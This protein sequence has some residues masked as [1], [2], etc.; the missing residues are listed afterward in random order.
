MVYGLPVPDEPKTLIEYIFPEIR[1]LR[2]KVR[3]QHALIK[4]QNAIIEEYGKMTAKFF[5]EKCNR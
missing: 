3:S 5:G 2:K 1:Y 4:E